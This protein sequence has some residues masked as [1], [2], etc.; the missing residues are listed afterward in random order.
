[1]KRMSTVFVSAYSQAPKGT[2]MSEQ[3]QIIGIMLEI[4][5]KSH[6]IVDAEC[7]FIT[8]IAKSYFRKLIVGFNFR[9]DIDEIIASVEENFLIPSSHAL[10]VALRTAYQRYVDMLDL[11]SDNGTA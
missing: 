5:R 1:M 2:K 10:V 6:I 4:D 9:T 8:S 7:T 11:K 3:G